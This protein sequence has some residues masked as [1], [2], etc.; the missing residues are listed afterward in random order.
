MPDGGFTARVDSLLLELASQE[1]TGCLIVTEPQGEQSTAWFRDGYVYAV[2]VPGRR[3]LLGPSGRV[4]PA[5]G[6]MGRT[7]FT[8]TTVT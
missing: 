7:T 8:V 2:S 4:A 5:R 6:A 1:A 3:P